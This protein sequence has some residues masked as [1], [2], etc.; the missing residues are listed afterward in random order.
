[1]KI[2]RE[3]KPPFVIGKRVTLG[4]LSAAVVVAILPYFPEHAAIV[5]AVEAVGL[6]GVQVWIANTY[7]ITTAEDG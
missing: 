6:F 1:M 3:G 5:R 4:A 2:K 7:K